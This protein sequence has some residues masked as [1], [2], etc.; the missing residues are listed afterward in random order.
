M[1]HGQ[2]SQWSFNSLFENSR[3]R[4]CPPPGPRP[5]TATH[6]SNLSWVA[7]RG[8]GTDAKNARTRIFEQPLIQ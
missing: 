8:R 5:H 1:A 3:R 4:R 7:G 2:A 6:I